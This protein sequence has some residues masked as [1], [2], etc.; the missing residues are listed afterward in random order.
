METQLDCSDPVRWLSFPLHTCATRHLPCLDCHLAIYTG[1]LKPG[2]TCYSRTATDAV[3]SVTREVIPGRHQPNTD[4]AER[5]QVSGAVRRKRSWPCRA[6]SHLQCLC[7]LV[8]R[9][10][11]HGILQAVSCQQ[12]MPCPRASQSTDTAAMPLHEI[13]VLAGGGQVN[14]TGT[15]LHVVQMYIL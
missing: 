1:V 15:V 8:G 7:A 14:L 5:R 11:L 9:K 13:R 2:Y 12:T 10:Q 3:L 4:N 6:A